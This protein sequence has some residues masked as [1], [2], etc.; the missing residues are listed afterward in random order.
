MFKRGFFKYFHFYSFLEDTIINY[1]KIEHYDANVNSIM[2]RVDKKNRTFV[3]FRALFQND[4]MGDF[5]MRKSFARIDKSSKRFLD[6]EIVKK[7]RIF[8][9][10]Q[11]FND[12]M[13]KEAC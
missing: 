13:A 8:H 2:Y 1:V 10:F 5:S 12:F 9:F 7:I 11:I 4:P 3:I 6:H